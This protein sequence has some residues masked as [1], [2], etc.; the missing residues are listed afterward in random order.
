M[1]VAHSADDL[2]MALSTAVQRGQ[3]GVRRRLGLSGKIP[4]EAAPHR[5]P[6]PRRRPRRRDPS[7][8]ARLLAAAPSPEGLGRRPLAGALGG[9]ARQDRRD[10]RQ[11]DAGHEISRRRHHRIPVR[12][13]RVLFHRD[14]HPHPGR[15]SRHREHHRYRPRAGADPHRRRRRAA[16]EAGR[17]SRSS[18]TPSN[19]ASTPRTRR[20]SV[21]R[22]ARSRNTIRRAASACGSIRRCIR[23]MSF[24]PITIRW[25]AS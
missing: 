4:A 17:E 7:R 20:P 16:R 8:R 3:I 15:A 1:K 10:L 5:D 6:D 25:S 19:A 24:R 14:E 21:L 11:G 9:R 22:P 23:A 2:M 13:R 18:A 12:G